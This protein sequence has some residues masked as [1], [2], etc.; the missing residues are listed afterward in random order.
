MLEHGPQREADGQLDLQVRV[1]VSSNDTSVVTRLLAHHPDQ[2]VEERALELLPQ[3]RGAFSF[4]WMDEHTLYA[5]R[6]P[7]GIRPLV[8][9]RLERGW[10]VAS[11]T[12]ALDI[13]GASF[14]REIEPGELIAIDE[15]GLRTASVRRPRAQGLPV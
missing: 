15:D 10:V 1:P 12:A 9:G 7:Q 2:S 5:A 4:I 13:V 11:E 8:L 6:D 14:I 3:I